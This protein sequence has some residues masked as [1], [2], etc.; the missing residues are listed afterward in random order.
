MAPLTDEDRLRAYNDALRNWEPTGFVCFELTETAQ[1]WLRT[2][3][4]G[5]TQKELAR[6]M[7]EYVNAGGEIDEVRETRPEWS[8]DYEFHYDLRFKIQGKPV[9]VETRLNYQPPFK[10]DEPSII[11]VSVHAP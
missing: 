6:L 3:F 5:I 7:W 11:V 9:Y 4:D 2:A 8:D 10:P 1:K